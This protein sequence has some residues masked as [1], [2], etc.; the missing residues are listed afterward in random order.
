MWESQKV[1]LVFYSSCIFINQN[2]RF[3]FCSINNNHTRL[4]SL[5]AFK[6]LQLSNPTCIS[7]NFSTNKKKSQSSQLPQLLPHN[8][9]RLELCYMFIIPNYIA[10]KHVTFNRKP[11]VNICRLP[12]FEKIIKFEN[13]LARECWVCCRIFT[14][15]CIPEICYIR[16]I[17]IPQHNINVSFSVLLTHSATLP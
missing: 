15:F 17:K 14:T 10:A 8:L 4:L 9:L 12:T 3:Y 11:N 13:M 6:T 1:F 5:L 7:S 2:R 16:W